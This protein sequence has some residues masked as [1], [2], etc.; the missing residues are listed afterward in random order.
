MPKH[1]TR[2]QLDG[3]RLLTPGKFNDL[4]HLLR[5]SFADLSES[6]DRSGHITLG[7]YF[8][9]MQILR[10]MLNELKYYFE[11]DWDYPEDGDCQEDLQED[12]QEDGDYQEDLQED[13]FEDYKASEHCST[14]SSPEAEDARMER[15]GGY[16]FF[17]GEVYSLG[18]YG[19]RWAYKCELED[20]LQRHEDRLR[21]YRKYVDGL[22]VIDDHARRQHEETYANISDVLLDT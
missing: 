15:S 13:M 17:F 19:R 10:D 21:D 2:L 5:M 11:G 9:D 7:M 14:H 3:S 20:T 12:P 22:A 1:G 4:E 18:L 16:V 8:E 6:A